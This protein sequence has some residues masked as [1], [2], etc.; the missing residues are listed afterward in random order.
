MHIDKFKKECMQVLYENAVD[1]NLSESG[2]SSMKLSELL[3]S[4]GI[5]RVFSTKNF[6]TPKRT[7]HL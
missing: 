1:Y 6:V 7:A 3:D 2:V 5:R 4:Q